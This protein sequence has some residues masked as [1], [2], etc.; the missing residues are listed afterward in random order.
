MPGGYA[1]AP[2]RVQRVS[3]RAPGG[4]KPVAQFFASDMKRNGLTAESNR[5]VAARPWISFV[6]VLAVALLMVLSSGGEEGR[7]GEFAAAAQPVS[8]GERPIL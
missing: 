5:K 6:V 1:G 2:A 3:R 4:F 7:E 8:I